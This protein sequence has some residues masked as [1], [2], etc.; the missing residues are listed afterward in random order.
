MIFATWMEKYILP[1]ECNTHMTILPTTCS[2]YT[3]HGIQTTKCSGGNTGGG[4]GGCMT[5]P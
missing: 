1:V 3:I 4:E 2:H 5:P